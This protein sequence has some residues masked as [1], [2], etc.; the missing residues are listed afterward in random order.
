MRIKRTLALI[1]LAAVVMS[2]AACNSTATSAT[3][4][5]S[6]SEV[7]SES[8]ST[9]IETTMP[10]SEETETTLPGSEDTEALDMET[11]TM[12]IGDTVVINPGSLGEAETYAWLEVEKNGEEWKVNKAEMGKL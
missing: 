11:L 3:S 2:A 10:E 5:S 12:K 6:T 4:Q 7:T 8:E 9:L 1:I